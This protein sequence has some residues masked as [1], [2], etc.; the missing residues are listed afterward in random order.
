M[1]ENIIGAVFA[2]GLTTFAASGAFNIVAMTD[3]QTTNI[4][5][6][7]TASN[8]DD[9]ADFLAAVTDVLADNSDYQHNRDPDSHHEKY[10]GLG[11]ALN[12]N[13]YNGECNGNGHLGNPDGNGKENHGNG[14]RNCGEPS[15][16]D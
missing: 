15:P 1:L 5:S 16:S 10:V 11:F 13:P 6:S 2:L 14:L 7:D 3:I 12:V 9:M 8:A 4:G